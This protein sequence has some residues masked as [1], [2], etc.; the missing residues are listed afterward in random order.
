MTV[1]SGVVAKYLLSGISLKFLI[2]YILE[3]TITVVLNILFHFPFLFF[4]KKKCPASVFVQ[5]QKHR[6]TTAHSSKT[7]AAKSEID[8]TKK[9]TFE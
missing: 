9:P 4:N 7:P 5:L 8:D 2:F 6:M 3:C 1:E